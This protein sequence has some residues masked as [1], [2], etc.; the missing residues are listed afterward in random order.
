M[1][2]QRNIIFFNL[3]PVMKKNKRKA[4]H[5]IYKINLK[6]KQRRKELGLSQIELDNITRLKTY[7]YES[8]DQEMT[9]TTI[10]IFSNALQLKPHQLLMEEEDNKPN[11]GG[12]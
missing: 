6:I 4:L 1:G 7:K 12:E 11:R 10:F 3:P 2:E 5:F 8:G 9:L